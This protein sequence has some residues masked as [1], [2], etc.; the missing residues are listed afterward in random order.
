MTKI[1]IDELLAVKGK[2][3]YWLAKQV[4]VTYPNMVNLIEGKTKLVKFETLEKIC[5]IL[6]CKLTDI[7]KFEE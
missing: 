3:R 2:T 4:G 5:N 1:L 6:E 7:I